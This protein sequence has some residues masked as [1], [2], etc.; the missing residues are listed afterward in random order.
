MELFKKIIE[1]LKKTKAKIAKLHYFVSQKRK[2]IIHEL[3]SYLVKTFDK[4]NH[5][6]TQLK[7]EQKPPLEK[8]FS[9]LPSHC[10]RSSS[11]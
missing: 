2:A 8:H 11:Q 10:T 1:N 3:T 7:Q 9:I 4:G 6:P 5:S